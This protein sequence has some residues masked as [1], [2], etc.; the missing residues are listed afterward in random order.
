MQNSVHF[1]LIPCETSSCHKQ[2]FYIKKKNWTRF[3]YRIYLFFTVLCLFYSMLCRNSN[4]NSNR[5][6]VITIF[7][8]GHSY[9][10]AISSAPHVN[11]LFELPS[12]FLSVFSQNRSCRRLFSFLYVIVLL[13]THY[14]CQYIL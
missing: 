14:H 10:W 2:P 5:K 6:K 7:P 13:I 11:I 12:F 8:K 4:C 3:H 1:S 9:L